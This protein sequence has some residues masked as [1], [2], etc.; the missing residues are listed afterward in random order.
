MTKKILI[1]G[2]AMIFAFG[3]LLAQDNVG[4][5]TTSPHSSAL[6]DMTAIDKGLLI[7]RVQLIAVTNGITPVNGP[8]TGLLVFNASGALDAGF[9]YWN[10]TEWVMVG[11][12]GAV[13]TCTTLDEAY[14]CG[15]AGVGRTVTANSG[16]V[17][18]TLPT[19]G[20]SDGALEAYSEKVGTWAIGAENTSTGVAILATTSG[21]TNQNNAIQGSSLSNYDAGV[22]GLGAG[23]VAGYYEGTGNGVG[24]YG[25]ITNP[26]SF[27]VSG[28][29][30]YNSRINGGYGVKGQGYAGVVGEAVVNDP[31]FGVYGMTQKGIGVQGQTDD[32][33]FYGVS[34]LNYALSGTGSGIGV[35]GDGITG[36]WGQTTDGGGYAVFGLNESTGI[37]DNNIGVGGEGY[38]G[39]YGKTTSGGFGVYSDGDFA[40]S[41]TKSFIIDHPSDPA[42]K[43]LKHY[44][45]ESPEVLNLYRGNIVLDQN[46]EAIV[47]LPEYFESINTNF[48]YNLTPIGAAVNLYIKEKI[49]NGQFKIAGG[50]PNMEVS[51]TVYAERN[52]AYVQKYPNAKAVEVEKRQKGT[53]IHPDLYGQPKEKAMFPTNN[54]QKVIK[55]KEEKSGKSGLKNPFKAE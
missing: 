22:G 31:G 50:N 54:M 41:G 7:P 24:V 43:M 55:L 32:S 36:V 27:G 2:I 10:G 40:S 53:Y 11:A 46:G 44:C 52:D 5:G 14:N 45:M 25:A 30:G 49:N 29:F 12:G 15:G 19:G 26:G 1:T 18:I 16:A 8:A 35:M 21:L 13:P 17:E 6:L 42:N 28:L 38:V 47:D 3:A 39:V 34:G 20:T 9:Y 4:I 51:W 33:D 48:S 37:I 23:G